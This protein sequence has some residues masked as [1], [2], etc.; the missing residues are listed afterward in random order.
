M[1][2]HAA[3]KSNIE[4]MRIILFMMVVSLHVS[5]PYL[6]AHFD[7]A[8][9]NWQFSNLMDGSS[10]LGSIGFVLIS[11][12]FMSG[13]KSQRPARRVLKL[14]PPLAFYFP[15]YLMLYY[16]DFRVANP[17]ASSAAKQ[18]LSINPLAFHQT[19]V[20]RAI[21]D[22]LKADGHFYP[23]WYVQV[24]MA[25]YLLAPYLNALVHQLSRE[26]FRNLIVVLFTI[27]SAS[28][29]LVYI[30]D[31]QFYRFD[32]FSSRLGLFVTIYFIGAYIRKHV[33]INKSAR[34]LF[35]MFA[36]GELLIVL[37][38]FIYN[39]PYSPLIFFKKIMGV[40]VTYPLKG[41]SGAFY[42]RSNSLVLATGV[43]MFLF[44]LKIEISSK[45]LS[46]AINWVS[47]KTYGAYICHVFWI[48]ILGRHLPI[49]SRLPYVVATTA[50]IV[51]VIVC[52]LATES[53]RQLLAGLLAPVFR[54][55]PA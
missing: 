21:M 11:G 7:S 35:L 38:T 25:T 14:L 13:S 2:N 29:T 4:L 22:F 15:I 12:Y 8:T 53:L 9:L 26:E 6:A 28:P 36:T 48:N 1:S 47:A 44:F 20:F 42:E 34:T 46:Q 37:L 23:L 55:Q 40:T 17:A 33:H 31:I 45:I 27:T 43:L 5:G 41:F 52:S 19:P 32:L 49:F 51:S 16:L 18:A 54:K 3:R 50:L 39:S 24:F 10:R 30:T